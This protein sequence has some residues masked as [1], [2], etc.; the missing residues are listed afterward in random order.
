M[1]KFV[2]GS[3]TGVIVAAAASY[4]FSEAIG[5]RTDDMTKELRE[6]R[7]YYR[8]QSAPEEPLQAQKKAY[9][10]SSEPSLAE[11]FQSKWNDQVLNF[12]RARQGAYDADSIINWAVD[13]LTGA[14]DAVETVENVGTT[15]APPVEKKLV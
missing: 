9:I 2:R 1:S 15:S 10:K 8:S 12:I 14:V 6:I 7:Q 11:E 5:A 3:L 4:S 13:K